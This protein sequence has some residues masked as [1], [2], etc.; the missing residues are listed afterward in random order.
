MDSGFITPVNLHYVRNH[1]AVPKL[2]WDSH[3]LHIGGPLVTSPR[4]YSMDEL[5]SLPFRELPVLLV[6]AGNRRKEQN[7]I[8]QG[9]G[10]SWGPSAAA[11]GLWKGVLLR[12]LLL[13]AGIQDDTSGFVCF[14][15]CDPLPGGLYGTS[16]SVLDAMDPARDVLIAFEQNGELLTPDHGK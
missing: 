2:H 9:K 4:D 3:R 14:E 11:V 15:G 7:M 8:K 10:F 5:V 16:M 6:C 13:L 1:G 12:D